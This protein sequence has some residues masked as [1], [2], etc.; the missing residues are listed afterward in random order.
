MSPVDSDSG[1]GLID[2]GDASRIAVRV[3]PLP[4]EEASPG[5]LF[6]GLP[7]ALRASWVLASAITGGALIGL[8]I[9]SLGGM[10]TL[11]GLHRA[12]S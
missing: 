1:S 5:A 12:T 9:A 8:A 2:E 6:A 4:E 11:N 10:S 3:T 7:C